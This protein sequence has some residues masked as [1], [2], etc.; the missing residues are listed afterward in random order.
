MAETTDKIGV[1]SK[2]DSEVKQKKDGTGSFTVHNIF[3]DGQKIGAGYNKKKIEDSGVQVGDTVR[4]TMVKKGDFWNLDSLEKVAPQTAATSTTTTAAFTQ[5]CPG[6]VLFGT[7]EVDLSYSRERVLTLAV[8]LVSGFANA[9]T[10]KA[11]MSLDQQLGKTV[12]IADHLL[13]YVQTG[14]VELTNESDA[15]KLAQEG[16]TEDVAV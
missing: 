11:A 1:V 14:K 8:S 13:R 4:A 6:P 16:V 15:A 2:I 3:V 7:Q 9:P 5:P 10:R 12:G